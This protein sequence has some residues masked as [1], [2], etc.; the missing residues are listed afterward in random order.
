MDAQ[1]KAKNGH[2][3]VSPDEMTASLNSSMAGLTE[4][5]AS[6]R[7]RRFGPN[8][9]EEAKKDPVFRFLKRYWGPMPWLLEFAMALTVLLGHYT[10][11]A[12]IF[13]LLT[14]NAV[15]GF[16]QSQN[17]RKAV[18]L[19]KKQLQIRAKVLRDGRWTLRDA[20]DLVPG[21]ILK[22]KLGDLVPADV[23]ILNGEVFVDA[24]AL[25]GESLPRELR[26]SDVVNS[27]SIVK[28]ALW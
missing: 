15:I 22:L 2:R 8:E 17:S 24:S 11:G 21:D 9:I 13:V 28:R 18:E 23:F 25:T 5:E 6:N 26:T 16:L 12:L 27:S 20:K 7:I 4:A 3:A 10:E 1:T 19:L 14:V